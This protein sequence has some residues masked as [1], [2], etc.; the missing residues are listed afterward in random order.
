MCGNAYLQHALPPHFAPTQR[1]DGR[2]AP[3]VPAL[4]PPHPVHTLQGDD[5]LAPPYPSFD[6]AEAQD[7]GREVES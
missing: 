4:T 6:G 3:L 7:E 5:W 2:L 1:G